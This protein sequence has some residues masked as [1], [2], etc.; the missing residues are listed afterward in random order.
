MQVQP[1]PFTAS[2]EIG[3]PAHAA[4]TT[5]GT[6]VAVGAQQEMIVGISYSGFTA[7]IV[8]NG[9]D[10]TGD[11]VAVCGGP[12][13]YSWNYEINCQKGLY[14]ECTGSGKG[15]AWLV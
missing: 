13:T 7:V 8:H 12:G 15:T 9:A 14:L 4:G 5:F 2:G 11:V 6:N 1:V 3:T 10:A